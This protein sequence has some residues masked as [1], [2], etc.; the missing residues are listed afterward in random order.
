MHFNH[1]CTC[2]FCF[3]FYLKCYIFVSRLESLNIPYTLQSFLS[4]PKDGLVKGLWKNHSHEPQ[5][6]SVYQRPTMKSLF[7]IYIYF[8]LG[9]HKI[10]H[11]YCCS[12]FVGR[13]KCVLWQ[14]LRRTRALCN[15][16][17]QPQL[18]I[19]HNWKQCLVSSYLFQ[20]FERGC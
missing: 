11:I 6:F 17:E 10:S 12:G 16:T 9:M 18:S 14:T 4:S 15:D 19:S 5:V 7:T 13:E 20:G 8:K 3:R 2:L 1:T